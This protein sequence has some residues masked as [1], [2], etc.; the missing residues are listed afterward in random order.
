LPALLD[1]TPQRDERVAA[2][3]PAIVLDGVSK[4]FRLPHRRYSTLKERALHPLRARTFDELHAV[5]DV[6]LTIRQGE[7]LGIVGRNGSGKSTLLKCL[8]RIYEIDRGR[9]EIAGRLS[10]F[11]ELGVGFNPDLTARD[12]V[13]I[14]GVMLGLSRKEARA[15]FDE[16]VAFA[17]LED[18]LDLKLKNYSS[19]MSVRLAFST[20]IQVDADI[21]L[22]DEV[23][24]VGDAAFQQKCFEQFQRMKD[25]GRTIV[26]VTHDMGAA[27]RFC[28]RAVLLEQGR[29]IQVGDPH[30]IALAY[31]ELNFGRL[32]HEGVE[33]GRYGDRA[34][35]EILGAWFESGGERVTAL[36]QR[37]PFEAVAEVRFHEPLV[38]PVFAITLRNEAG[39]TV[40]STSTQWQHRDTGRFVP[41]ETAEMRV[42]LDGWFAP[43]HYQLTPS[44]AR[45]GAG[46]DALDV[47]EDLAS[48]MIHATRMTGG[49]VDPPHTIEIRRGR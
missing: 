30:A 32:V 6:S 14:N 47:R 34:A 13:V 7:F 44:V 27:E 31:N 5:D 3:P 38:D 15:R 16:I 48:L 49:V 22:V 9:I 18:F 19:G 17:E 12:N 2:A 8:A 28:D 24:A 43:S 4:T 35:A 23:L 46:A 33:E 42:A 36:D 39:A 45:A 10:P 21:L 20:A 11:I 1:A 41:G 37:E 29:V 26:F 40:F 25:E